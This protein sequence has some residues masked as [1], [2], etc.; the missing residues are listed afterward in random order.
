M[1]FRLVYSR[2]VIRVD[3]VGES[4]DYCL[5]DSEQWNIKIQY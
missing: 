4:I 2:S 1:A 5:D 3:V